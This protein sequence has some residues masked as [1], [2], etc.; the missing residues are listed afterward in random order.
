MFVTREYDYALRI[1]RA[2]A[3][4]E[5]LSVNQV[6]AAEEVPVAY[7]YKILKKLEHSSIVRGYRGAQ[8]GYQLEKQPKD[9][10]LYDV[11]VAVEGELYI[12]ECMRKGY[13]CSN[14]SKGKHC[15]IHIE[16]GHMQAD[17]MQAMQRRTMADML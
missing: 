9:I 17:F 3:N 1:L 12:N 2:L 10:T 14:N 11:Y 15:A 16:L 4:G 13:V 7:A 8:G 6:C 5:R